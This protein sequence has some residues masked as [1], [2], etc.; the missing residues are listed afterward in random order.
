MLIVLVRWNGLREEEG[1][2]EC[3]LPLLEIE[4]GKLADTSAES[5]GLTNQNN[6]L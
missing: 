4:N 5:D 6:L 2:G 1:A 3:K